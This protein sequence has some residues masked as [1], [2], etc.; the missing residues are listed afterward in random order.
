MVLWRD[1]AHAVKV[2]SQLTLRLSRWTWPKHMS[3]V[4]R[5]RGF[6][7]YDHRRECQRDTHTGWPGRKQT[8]TWTAYGSHMARNFGWPLGAPHGP[9]PTTGRERGPPSDNCKEIY[10]ANFRWIWNPGSLRLNSNLQSCDM[11][12]M[13]CFLKPLSLWSFL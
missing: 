7:P 8:P 12:H 1:F 9:Q 3:P 11:I 4:I 6:S 5:S 13:C 10:S 2:S